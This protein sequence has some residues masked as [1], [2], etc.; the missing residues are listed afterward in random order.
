MVRQRII[1]CPLV[2]H[3]FCRKVVP[4]RVTLCEV[5]FGS[6]GVHWNGARYVHVRTFVIMLRLV[7]YAPISLKM[8]FFITHS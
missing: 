7:V 5:R 6:G 8:V 1:A 3:D 4:D 2:D